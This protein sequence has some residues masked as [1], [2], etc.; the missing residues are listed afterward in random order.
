MRE[1]AGSAGSVADGAEDTKGSREAAP[2]L[3][4]AGQ[5]PTGWSLA[6][7]RKARCRLATPFRVLRAVCDTSCASRKLPHPKDLPPAGR[8]PLG[9]VRRTRVTGDG[10]PWGKSPARPL[11]RGR[12]RRAAPG[13]PRR[14]KKVYD[15]FVVGNR[16]RKDEKDSEEAKGHRE[17]RKGESP[18]WSGPRQKPRHGSTTY[19]CTP[20]GGKYADLEQTSL[21]SLM[22][23][24]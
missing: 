12:T 21:S 8:D 4:D 15:G 23:S 24:E 14:G 16:R 19:I 1:L 13:R 20:A 22:A 6:R 9:I 7:I 10:R 18:H 2:S 17:G 11:P 5:G 3:P